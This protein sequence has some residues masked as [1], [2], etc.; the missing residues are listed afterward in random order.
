MGSYLCRLPNS[1]CVCVCWGYLMPVALCS[2]YTH[3]QR[4]TDTHSGHRAQCDMTGI[5]LR[6]L[7]LASPPPQQQQWQIA[8]SIHIDNINISSNAR[9]LHLP[10]ATWSWHEAALS[11]SRDVFA[12]ARPAQVTQRERVQREPYKCCTKLLLI[13]FKFQ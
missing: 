5:L 7:L 6:E 13:F 9:N 4:V 11:P 10:L 8:S 12:E 1:V 3:T 2:T